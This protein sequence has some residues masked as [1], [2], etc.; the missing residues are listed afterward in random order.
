MVPTFTL[1]T[2]ALFMSEKSE[3]LIHEM[4]PHRGRRSA[5]RRVGRVV[6]LVSTW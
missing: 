2:T 4:A 6:D 5:A 3:R 1:K